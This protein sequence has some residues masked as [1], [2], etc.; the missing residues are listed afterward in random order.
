MNKKKKP[1]KDLLSDRGR[2][3]LIEA[4]CDN[5]ISKADLQNAWNSKDFS[6][7][8]MLYFTSTNKKYLDFLDILYRQ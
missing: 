1:S 2:N 6:A 4:L 3:L 5:K 8:D 7:E